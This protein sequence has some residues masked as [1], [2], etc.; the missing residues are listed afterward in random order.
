MEV[1]SN[2]EEDLEE[3]KLELVHS[4]DKSQYSQS[5]QKQLENSAKVFQMSS[6]NKKS[7]LEDNKVSD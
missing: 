2:L 4:T 7:Y 6:Q 1:K 3:C 5:P